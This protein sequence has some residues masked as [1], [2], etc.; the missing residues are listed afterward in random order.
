MQKSFMFSTDEA[1]LKVGQ[2]ASR[3]SALR[4]ALNTLNPFHLI[5]LVP[6]LQ[7]GYFVVLDNFSVHR[8]V[9]AAAAVRNGCA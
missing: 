6:K 7:L 4:S 9:R 2:G 8:N 5:K 3:R 1:N